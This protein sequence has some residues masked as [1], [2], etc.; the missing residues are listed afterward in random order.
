MSICLCLESD[1]ITRKRNLEVDIN[2][3]PMTGEKLK[4]S[5]DLQKTINTMGVQLLPAKE[6][7]CILVQLPTGDS[8]F[9]ML[10]DC[11]PVTLWNEFLRELFSTFYQQDLKVDILVVTHI[12]ADHIGGAIPLFQDEIL[13][14][15]VKEVWYNGL[16]ELLSEE[17]AA[18]LP[19]ELEKK[20][21][22]KLYCERHVSLDGMKEEISAKQAYTF[23]SLLRKYQVSVNKHANH[24]AITAL[25]PTFNVG[26]D[27]QIDF[28]S[29]CKVSLESLLKKYRHELEAIKVGT[30]V[31]YCEESEAAF[32][33]AMLNDKDLSVVVEDISSKAM[34]LSSVEN[35]AETRCQ[36]DFSVTNI[37]SITF[38]VRYRGLKFLFLGDVS[39][40][41]VIEN[42]K[43]WSFRVKENLCFDMIKMPHHGSQ[44]NGRAIL[45]ELDARTFL[46]STNGRKHGHPDKE[47]VA[48]ILTRTTEECRKISFNYK[49]AIFELFNDKVLQDEYLYRSD[50]D[51]LFAWEGDGI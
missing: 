23:S 12:D 10:I 6:G 17:E 33:A 28:F 32:E 1:F 45:D 40:S 16:G 42:I 36:E 14:E 44:R 22:S 2:C 34:D 38:S 43:N 49:H 20:I 9:R 37:S 5:I 15:V 50:S 21:Y 24:K 29:P 25:T 4:M 26:G 30:K 7:D 27:I 35:W 39:V 46:I 19:T 31:K 8:V 11:G 13:H 3:F 47:C 41:A 48:R 51:G 18:L